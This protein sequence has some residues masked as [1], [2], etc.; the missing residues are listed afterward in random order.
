MHNEHTYQSLACQTAIDTENPREEFPVL[1]KRSQKGKQ[2]AHRLKIW[3]RFFLWNAFMEKI[4][5]QFCRI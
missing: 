2:N 3:V 1:K 4:R 5:M